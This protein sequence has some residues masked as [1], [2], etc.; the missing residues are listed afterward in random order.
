MLALRQLYPIQKTVDFGCWYTFQWFN[1]ENGLPYEQPYHIHVKD[2]SIEV[3]GEKV[4]SYDLGELIQ[5]YNRSTLLFDI[6]ILA[7]FKQYTHKDFFIVV[8]TD[9]G[10]FKVKNRYVESEITSNDKYRSKSHSKS[11]KAVE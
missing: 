7:I 8:D 11:K 3:D 6:P 1:S 2:I 5:Q 4:F 9:R 10:S